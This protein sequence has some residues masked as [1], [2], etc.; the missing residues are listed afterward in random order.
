MA[1]RE[2]FIEM[3]HP[4]NGK[5]QYPGVPYLFSDINREEPTAAPSLGQHNEEIY[6]ERLGYTRNDLD[7]FREAGVI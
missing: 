6:C 1:A 7:K 5:R 3:K 4:G 2:F